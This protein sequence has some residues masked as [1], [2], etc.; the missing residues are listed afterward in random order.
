MSETT[1]L[2]PL[3]LEEAIALLPA[4]EVI[5]VYTR[6]MLG[7]DWPREAVLDMLASAV[8]IEPSGPFA[9]ALGHGIAAWDKPNHAWLVE[10]VG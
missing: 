6:S 1:D 2:A 5:H 7:A 4:G 10:T 3:T 9:T 8:R